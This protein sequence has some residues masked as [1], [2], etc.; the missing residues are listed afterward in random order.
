MRLCR[1]GR[2]KQRNGG[3]RRRRNGGA[4]ETINN[5]IK[6][7]CQWRKSAVAKAAAAS[8]A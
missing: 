5:E 7:Q 4:Q 1:N 8:M 6:R 3:Y 2:E